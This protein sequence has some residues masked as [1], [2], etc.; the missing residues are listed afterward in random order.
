MNFYYE[1]NIGDSGTF[2]ENLSNIIYIVGTHWINNS[3]FEIEKVFNNAEKAK[4]YIEEQM[5]G[6]EYN[7]LGFYDIKCL[8]VF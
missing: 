3:N 2:T 8:E 7:G 1:N 4:K 5:E 6:K